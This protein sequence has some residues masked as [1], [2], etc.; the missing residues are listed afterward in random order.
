MVWG[1]AKLVI[2]GGIFLI[3]PTDI[4]S[5]LWVNCPPKVTNLAEHGIYA[6]GRAFADLSA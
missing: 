5:A 3:H 1:I 6:L 2:A 4:A